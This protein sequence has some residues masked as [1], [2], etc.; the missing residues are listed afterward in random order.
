MVEESDRFEY[1]EYLNSRHTRVNRGYTIA[2]VLLVH[3]GSDISVK[4]KLPALYTGNV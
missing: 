1:G 2:K 3:C 4:P